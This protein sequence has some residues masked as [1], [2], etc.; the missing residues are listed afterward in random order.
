MDATSEGSEEDPAVAAAQIEEVLLKAA[1][2]LD[3]E[4]FPDQR[5]LLLQRVMDAYSRLRHASSTADKWGTQSLQAWL[6]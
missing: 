6:Q 5:E 4:G 2:Q 1:E 3:L